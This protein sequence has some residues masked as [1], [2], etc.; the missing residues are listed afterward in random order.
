MNSRTI[1]FLLKSSR[2][3]VHTVKTYSRTIEFLLKSSR[4]R[5]HTV[6]TMHSS[7]IELAHLLNVISNNVAF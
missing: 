6:K 4:S 1:E 3:R 2:S 5:V 7:W